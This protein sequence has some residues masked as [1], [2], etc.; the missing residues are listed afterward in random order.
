MPLTLT[1]EQ[2]NLPA[3]LLNTLKTMSFTVPT[4]IQIKAIPVGLTGKDVMGTAQTGTGKTAAFSI[5]LIVSLLHNPQQ[6]ALI[7]APTREL[8]IQIHSVIRQLTANSSELVSSLLI[9]GLSMKQQLREL[10]RRPRILIATPGRL[11]DHLGRQSNLLTQ[12]SLLVLDEADR[13]LDMGFISQLNAIKRFLPKKRQTFMF[14][15]TFPKSIKQLAKEYLF[16][17]VEVSVGEIA[18]PIQK[19]SQAIIQ[20]THKEKND[21]LVDELNVRQGSVLIFARTKHRTNRLT[22]YLLE[23][24]YK[25][26]KIHGDCSQGQRRSALEGFRAGKFRILVATDIASRGLDINDIGH[27]INY[28]LPQAPEDY[29][30]RIGR[31]ARNGKNGQALCLLTPED[32]RAWQDIARFT[33]QTSTGFQRLPN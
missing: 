30:H 10:A 26:A 1:F 2:F 4:P 31:T 19:V 25:A 13:M 12:T 7:L 15:A 22:R 9:G 6:N 5:P 29:V 27:V 23:F 14:S 33:G 18:K 17:P 32:R 3:S 11:V 24:G 21:R 16:Q 20:T 8:A 28:D